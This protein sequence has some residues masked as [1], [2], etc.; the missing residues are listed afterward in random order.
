V[1]FY[2]NCFYIVGARC[3]EST[4]RGEVWTNVSRLRFVRSV[5]N[6]H[7]SAGQLRHYGLKKGDCWVWLTECFRQAVH[8]PVLL[9]TAWELRD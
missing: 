6:L 3:H 5:F 4:H 7:L 2:I 1:Y 9:I 8:L